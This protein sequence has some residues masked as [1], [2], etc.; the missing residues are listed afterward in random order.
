MLR[1]RHIG[2]DVVTIVFQ[3]LG[4][5]PLDVSTFRSKFVHVFLLV[6]QETDSPVSYR[7]VS[8]RKAGVPPF[9]PPLPEDGL[10]SNE[11]VQ[12]GTLRRFLLAKAINAEAFACRAGHLRKLADRTHSMLLDDL[13]STCVT[14]PQAWH[15]CMR[16]PRPCPAPTPRPP[17]VLESAITAPP[18]S[19]SYSS[20]ALLRCRV[21]S[22][23]FAPDRVVVECGQ[24]SS[25]SACPLKP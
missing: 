14:S 16:L 8:I 23:V 13:V 10:F 17:G 20:L 15:H 9:G 4:C 25:L 18:C 7:V 24:C 19:A 1:K 11:D 22:L 5:A 21:A 3:E 2:N 6:R 12:D